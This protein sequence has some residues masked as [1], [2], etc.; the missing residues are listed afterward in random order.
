MNDMSSAAKNKAGTSGKNASLYRMVM[1]KHVCPYGVKSR[2]LLER[3]GYTVEDHHLTTREQTDAFKERHGVATTPQTFIGGE[4][5]GGYDSL[6][7]YFGQSLPAEGETSYKPVLAIFGVALGLAVALSLWAFGTA[8]TI[9]GAEWFVA[10]SMAMLAMTKLQDVETFSTMFVGYDLLARRFVPY[11][12]AY[13]FLEGAAA[14]LMA[15]RLLPWL[16]IPIALFIGTVG[17]VSVFYAVYVQKR[18]IKCACVGG[19]GNVPLGF[20][21]LTENLAMMGMGLWMLLRALA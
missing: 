18:E 2:W 12:Y 21:S 5:I 6:R 16:S 4:R 20:V 15:G 14:I 19:S 1:E 13:P 10:F 7:E 3:N 9:R 8:L 17:A 11:A